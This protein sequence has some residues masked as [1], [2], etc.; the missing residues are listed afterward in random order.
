MF[1]L[2]PIRLCDIVT[3]YPR[4]PLRYR[5]TFASLPSMHLLLSNMT[6]S[7]G[8]FFFIKMYAFNTKLGNKLYVLS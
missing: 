7:Y 3:V 5:L 8:C 6:D 2:M 1:P 4:V